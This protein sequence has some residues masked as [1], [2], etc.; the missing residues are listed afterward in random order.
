[1]GELLRPLVIGDHV[2]M[3]G[4]ARAD[5][6]ADA[7]GCAEAEAVATARDGGK[8]MRRI[9]DIGAEGL[10]ARMHR[11]DG[12]L[13]G[14]G[15]AAAKER[16]LLGLRERQHMMFLAGG[17][18]I[19]GAA[20]AAGFLKAPGIAIEADALVEVAHVEIH[21]AHGCHDRV[22]HSC[23]HPGINW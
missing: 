2:G 18:Q 1:M 16:G 11:V 12:G 20:V 13:V 7:I 23:L 8:I 22:A 9:D 5:R 6:L 14:D 10:G 17:A 15:E 21:A 4:D 3:L 19:D